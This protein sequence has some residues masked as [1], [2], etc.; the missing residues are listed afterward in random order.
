MKRMLSTSST[1][2]LLRK[3]ERGVT[4][5]WAALGIASLLGV[6]AL[7][8]D[9]GYMYVLRNQMQTTVD[10]AVNA[11]VVQL[12]DAN[13]A[14][15]AALN[16]VEQ[17]MPASAHGT[18]LTNTDFEVGNWNGVT[19]VFTLNGLP[20]NAVRATARRDTTNSNAARTFF[21]SI[22]GDDLVSIA[23]QAIAVQKVFVA[24]CLLAL[25]PSSDVAFTLDSNAIVDLTG[26][27]VTINSTNAS[28][29]TTRSNAEMAANNICIAGGYEQIGNSTI[30]PTPYTGCDPLP[31]PL[32]GLPLP[33]VGA[34][35]YT[36]A[37]Y[38]SPGPNLNPGV[39][40][41]GIDFNSNTVRVLNPGIYIMKD[42]PFHTDSNTVISG[43]GV[44]IFLTGTGTNPNI[45]NL[46]AVL[47]LDS[48]STV[49][50][51]APAEGT[52]GGILVFQNPAIGGT[53]R[54]NSNSNKVF[55]GV[56]YIPNGDVLVDSNGVIASTAPCTMLIARRFH[57]DSNAGIEG[58]FDLNPNTTTCSVAIPEGLQSGST[59][60]LV[61]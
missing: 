37:S 36:N 53:H 17:N 47:D 35:N 50:L 27:G 29:L 60:T 54:I 6:A 4:I 2:A 7:T 56:I 32:A 3:D 8:V 55:E 1:L 10:T 59:A 15:T 48:N 38:T 42:G 26:C 12:P 52:Y 16:Y 51:T 40:C 19:K 41:G 25:D 22:L 57:F 31:D 18:V 30:T 58:V 5:V 24:P 46:G 20:T 43:T 34:C 14:R 21:A 9:M 23:T 11:A 49:N 13:A 61:R 33:T 39:Y 28:A 45:E 44:M